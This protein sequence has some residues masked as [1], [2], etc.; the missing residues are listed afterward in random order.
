M[1]KPNENI[2]AAKSKNRIVRTLIIALAL[3]FLI[4]MAIEKRVEAHI[5]FSK[6]RF[7]YLV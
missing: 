3:I 4:G 2:R 7:P 1:W 5:I 6:Y